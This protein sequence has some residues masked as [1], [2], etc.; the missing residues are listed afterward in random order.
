VHARPNTRSPVLSC[1]VSTVH[2]VIVLTVGAAVT[3]PSPWR[4]DH[5]AVVKP[6]RFVVFVVLR[7]VLML[8]APTVRADG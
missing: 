4:N 3:V 8:A 5:G 2:P 6:P 7:V 1:R